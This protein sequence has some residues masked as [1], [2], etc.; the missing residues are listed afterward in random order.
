MRACGSDPRKPAPVISAASHRKGIA[1]SALP[2]VL[3]AW[4][5][6]RQS[7]K[8]ESFGT[9]RGHVWF[10]TGSVYRHRPW[11][12]LGWGLLSGNH[13]AFLCSRGSPGLS[14]SP[15]GCNT[16][17]TMALDATLQELLAPAY[18]SRT[19]YPHTARKTDRGVGLSARGGQ[20]PRPRIWERWTE[21]FPTEMTVV[22]ALG[23]DILRYRDDCKGRGPQ[24]LATA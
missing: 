12:A 17:H 3:P 1:C 8:R 23:L 5:R 13:F 10:Q 21:Y 7:Q 24:P 9:K 18:S 4:P 14:A 11:E 6:T 19:K 20:T 15:P 16:W 2:V 22:G